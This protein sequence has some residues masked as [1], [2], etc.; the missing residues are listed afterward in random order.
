[1]IIGCNDIRSLATNKK[2][3]DKIVEQLIVNIRKI[4]EN[5]KNSFEEIYVSTIPP[6][7]SPPFPYNILYDKAVNSA[8]DAANSK[9]RNLCKE[10]LKLILLD[11]YSLLNSNKKEMTL[12]GIHMNSKAYKILGNEIEKKN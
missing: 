8:L 10:D 2:E 11:T 12:D 3:K 5:H 6:L 1:M 4:I 7:F 9:I